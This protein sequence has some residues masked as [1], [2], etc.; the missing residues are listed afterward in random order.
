[1]MAALATAPL[2][3]GLAA[4]PGVVGWRLA[5]WIARTAYLGLLSVAFPAQASSAGPA[6]GAAAVLRAIAF[7]AVAEYSRTTTASEAF[8]RARPASPPDPHRATAVRP[9]RL[10]LRSGSRS[11]IR[12]ALESARSS[13]GRPLSTR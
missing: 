12:F 4:A 9:G 1:M 10:R 5:A 3:Y 7:V 6:W 8:R 11:R 13:T 2:A